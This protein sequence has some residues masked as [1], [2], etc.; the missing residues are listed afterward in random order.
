MFI[1]SENAQGMQVS[2][3]NTM[4]SREMHAATTVSGST[5][6]QSVGGATL[7]LPVGDFGDDLRRMN[8]ERVQLDEEL[9]ESE[10]KEI[11]IFVDEYV[12]FFLC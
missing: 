5:A 9:R 2:S 6:V 11:K 8:A 1:V 4:A 3:S 12:W 10:N 7:S